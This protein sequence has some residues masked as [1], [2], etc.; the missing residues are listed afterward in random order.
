MPKWGERQ[1]ESKT[2]SVQWNYLKKQQEKEKRFV[3]HFKIVYGK[4]KTRQPVQIKQAQAVQRGFC[5]RA[6]SDTEH[7]TGQVGRGPC[8]Q[9]TATSGQK[10]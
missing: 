7:P 1:T 6:L 4:W 2:W 5:R 8:Q 3:F 9:R 10:H